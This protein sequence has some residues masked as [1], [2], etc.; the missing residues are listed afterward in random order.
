MSTEEF[1][2]NE[3]ISFSLANDP[4]EMRFSSLV[5]KSRQ[6]LLAI[7]IS[8][9]DKSKVDMELDDLLYLYDDNGEV[10]RADAQLVQ[11]NSYP[12]VILKILE[13]YS[14]D[15]VE[16]LPLA[17][18]AEE[19]MLEQSPLLVP[20]V[21]PDE[22]STDS[23]D[24]VELSPAEMEVIKRNEREDTQDLTGL[25]DISDADVLDVDISEDEVPDLSAMA[26]LDD[27][28]EIDSDDLI[29][30]LQKNGPPFSSGAEEIEDIY[31]PQGDDDPK[32]DD[33]NIAQLGF[34]S[35]SVDDDAEG[36]EEALLIESAVDDISLMEIDEDNSLPMQ[37]LDLETLDEMEKDEEPA[38]YP[39]TAEE[40][41]GNDR[42]ETDELISS[43]VEWVDETGMPEWEK[44]DM[45][46]AP[47]TEG[48]EVESALDDDYDAE[49]EKE[50]DG[51][52]LEEVE[53]IDQLPEITPVPAVTQIPETFDDF[54]P[55][56]I[57]EAGSKTADARDDKKEITLKDL[58]DLIKSLESKISA[59]ENRS[60]KIEDAQRRGANG[61][62]LKI[63]PDSALVVVE[64]AYE[65]LAEVTVLVDRPFITPLSFQVKGHIESCHETTDII[66]VRIVFDD[67][68]EV[69]EAIKE[70][71]AKGARDLLFLASLRDLSRD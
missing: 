23:D 8:N 31:E 39:V 24:T 29:D 59:G 30:N 67:D 13:T 19:D 58:A 9:K 32:D 11:N 53:R 21:E 52:A 55:V 68:E 63:E 70:Y 36:N 17:G 41:E 51:R 22:S 33:E 26:D 49:P 37:N 71:L 20:P 43:D 25:E 28:E 46:L 66:L 12:L 60:A 6:N 15:D 50:D 2:I 45:P 34:L 69:T 4:S 54:F 64:Q 48:I 27:L 40:Q 57:Y 18:L 7:I 65:P 14:P 3:K 47:D 38:D 62:C 56:T 42:G 44:P 35:S 5:K 61:Y 16:S 10:K 1:S